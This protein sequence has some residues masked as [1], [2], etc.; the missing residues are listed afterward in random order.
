MP[1]Y[2]TV[3]RRYFYTAY[4]YLFSCAAT[5]EIAQATFFSALK[6]IGLFKY[7]NGRIMPM[8]A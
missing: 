7:T 1:D 8:D 3:Y 6:K 2:E 4:C 5:E